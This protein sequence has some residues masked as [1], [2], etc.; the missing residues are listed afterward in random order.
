[1]SDETGQKERMLPDSQSSQSQSDDSEREDSLSQQLSILEGQN[2]TLQQQIRDSERE[3]ERLSSLLETSRS[4][5]GTYSPDMGPGGKPLPSRVLD[6][7]PV[8]KERERED[9]F[10]G[11]ANE[12]PDK[13]LL[14]RINRLLT[15][16]NHIEVR[17]RQLL[18]E[19]QVLQVD[20]AEQQSAVSK[21]AELN[22]DLRKDIEVLRSENLHVSA[23]LGRVEEERGS[24]Q[25]LNKEL[26]VNLNTCEEKLAQVCF[27]F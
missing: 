6:G 25:L 8:L 11:G 3:R 14:S 5:S 16:K 13:D 27:I 9:S 7:R 1:M 17:L 26:R 10:S 24:I 15:E 20:L 2:R 12:D 23:E 4:P 22:N 19:N 18:E 21:G